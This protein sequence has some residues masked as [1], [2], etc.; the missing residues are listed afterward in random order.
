MILKS[1][2]E[3]EI[4]IFVYWAKPFVLAVDEKHLDESNEVLFFSSDSISIADIW[5]NS[6]FGRMDPNYKK[7]LTET[8][9]RNS[10]VARSTNPLLLM[11]TSLEIWWIQQ[12]SMDQQQ[13]T[14]LASEDLLLKYEFSLKWKVQSA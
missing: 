8:L 9:F 6:G 5:V 3:V 12:R 1:G 11:S 14:T 13:H 2:V 4:M 10:D 7:Y